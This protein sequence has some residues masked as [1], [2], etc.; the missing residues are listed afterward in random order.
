[1]IP[2]I[3][4]YCWFGGKDKPDDVKKYIETWKKQLP[5]YELKEWNEENFS[6]Q[7]APLYVQ[8]AYSVGKYAFVSDYARIKAL[9]EYGGVYFDTDLEVVKPFDEYLEG[10]SLVMGFE[11]EG[12]LIT[13]FI[14][15]E[16]EHPFI[17]Q[18]LDTYNSRK[19]INPDGSYDLT[20]INDHYSALAKEWGVDLSKN[21]LQN[22]SDTV[23]VYPIEYFCGFDTRNWHVATTDNTCT[24]HHMASSWAPGKTKLMIVV[25]SV[26]Q[27]VLGLKNYDK[28]RKFV[29]GL[30]KK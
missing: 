9:K 19:F 13:A 29:N 16:K 4:H 12:L 6:V 26:L 24:I 11:S 2:K 30:R 22:I 10:K 25:I 18:F 3:I 28:F 27:K 23:I 15:C 21:E 7:D 20:T 1:M 8:D 17:S 5:D 14:A